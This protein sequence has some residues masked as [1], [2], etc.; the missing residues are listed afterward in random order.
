M[1]KNLSGDL[2]VAS[3]NRL[4]DGVVVFLGDAG[5][6]TTGLDRAAVARDKRA[7]VVVVAVEMGVRHNAPR[8]PQWPRR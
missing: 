4:A 1:A 2:S 7:V 5:D 8:R 6:W 3:A